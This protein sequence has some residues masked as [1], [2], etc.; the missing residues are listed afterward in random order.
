MSQTDHFDRISM[1]YD[2]LRSSGGITAMHEAI[3]READLAGKDVVEI[4]CGTG[5]HLLILATAF[6]CH[7]AGV[8]PSEGMLGEARR[9]LPDADLRVGI[10]ER[11]PFEDASFDAG[12]MALVVHHLDRP[13]AFLEARRILRS[14]GRLVIVTPDPEAFARA[15]MAPL[16]PSY[17]DV[18]RARFPSLEQL[19]C[20]LSD[21]GF[22][23]VRGVPMRVPRRFSREHAIERIRGR[24]ASTFDLLSPEE[25][26]EGLARAER[27]L[28]DPVEYVL[29]SMIVVAAR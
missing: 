23:R 11:L 27:E 20:E 29:E 22:A 5:S 16:F 26:N 15:W 8:D 10:A 17:V 24:Y 1:R 18:E 7:V 28:P 6:D 13:R 2:E 4:G 25:Y 3:V 9:K 12:L 21:A 14:E 19:E